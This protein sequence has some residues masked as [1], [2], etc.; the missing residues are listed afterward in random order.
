M[1]NTSTPDGDHVVVRADEDAPARYGW[2]GEDPAIDGIACDDLRR[3]SR[4]QHDRLPRFAEQIDLA[5]GRDGRRGVN[6]AEPLP[7][8]LLAGL[9]V[10]TRN[11]ADVTGHVQESVVV[12]HRGD[13][14][15]S[16][17]DM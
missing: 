16:G 10:H 5:V 17:A 13:V 2:R 12:H 14:R 3:A 1:E 6:P 8:D 4:P 15:G 7:P 11:H 9:R